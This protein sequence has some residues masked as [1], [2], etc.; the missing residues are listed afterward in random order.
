MRSSRRAYSPLGADSFRTAAVVAME[1]SGLQDHLL[2]DHLDVLADAVAIPA[3]RVLRHAGLVLWR[4]LIADLGLHLGE[5][6]AAGRRLL[7]GVDE[8]AD[9]AAEERQMSLGLDVAVPRDDLREV[10]LIQG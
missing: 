9:I 4:E 5:R 8:V 10:E 2:V 7:H 3:Q 1:S 6:G